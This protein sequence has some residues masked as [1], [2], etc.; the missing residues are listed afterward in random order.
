MAHPISAL[1]TAHDVHGFNS[2]VP[3][4]DAWLK[5]TA[6]QHQKKGISRAHVLT[7][8]GEPDAIIGFFTMAIRFMTPKSELPAGMA[9][10]LPAN[11][12]GYT[13]ARLAISEAQKG[14]GYGELLLSAA[15]VKAKD[16]ADNV[17]GFALFVDAKDDH[18]ANFYLHY[19][20]A[21][22]PSNPLVLAIPIAAIPS[23]M[24]MAP[25]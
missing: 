16:A 6:R 25:R 17:G 2:G 20:F 10:S 18:A 23:V 4:L 9:K 14:K 15:M 1:T 11:V 3:E 19:G 21:Q 24:S 13:L 5:N 8:D 22:L 7:D 12:P